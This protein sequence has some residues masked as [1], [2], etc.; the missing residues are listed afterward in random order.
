MSSEYSGYW[1]VAISWNFVRVCVLV[2]LLHSKFTLHPKRLKI[3]YTVANILIAFA[4][5]LFL[6]EK[7]AIFLE[8]MLTVLFLEAFVFFSMTSQTLTTLSYY[9]VLTDGWLSSSSK[10][11]FTGTSTAANKFNT[12]Y[13][14]CSSVKL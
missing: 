6:T 13:S 12:S 9:V 14:Y 5:M 8:T 10:L 3:G 4:T 11:R 7:F 2:N 1:T